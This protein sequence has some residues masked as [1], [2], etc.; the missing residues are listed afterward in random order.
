[1]WPLNLYIVSSTFA[2]IGGALFAMLMI[3]IAKQNNIVNYKEKRNRNS[4]VSGVE[5]AATGAPSVALVV[6][7][8]L[9]RCGCGRVVGLA[10][11]VGRML[12]GSLQKEN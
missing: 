12:F 9:R 1:M 3:K 7:H 8:Q 5:G 10:S 4:S 11:V 2:D 6:L